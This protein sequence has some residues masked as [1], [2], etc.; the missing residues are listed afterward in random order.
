M[1]VATLHLQKADPVMAQ[2]IQRVGPCQFAIREPTFETLARSIT[3]QQLHG[4]AARSIFE[5]LRKAVGR[6]FTA[7]AFLKL[8]QE[9]LRACGLSRQKIA[10][11]TDLAER[12]ARREINFRKLSALEDAEIISV[13]S[14]VRGVGVW[15]VQMFLIFALQRPNVM[16]LGDFGIRN[17]VRKAY[18]LPELPKPADLARMAEKWHPYCSVA[19]WY[20]WRSLDVPA[21]I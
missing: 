6:R 4:K 21:G 15:T 13:L 5:R 17:A 19:S 2:I 8:T 14:Q 3:F 12:V 9:E 18:G 16:P 10:S 20:L 1:E 11:L 7:T